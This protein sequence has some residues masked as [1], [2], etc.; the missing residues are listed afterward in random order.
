MA[1]SALPRQVMVAPQEPL[2]T[3]GAAE[4]YEHKVHDLFAGGCHHLVV[5]LRG[6]A[7]IDS[8]GV[9]ALVRGHTTAQRMGGTFTL[10][11]PTAAVLDVLRLSRLDSVFHIRESL[12]EARIS[13]VPWPGLRLTVLGAAL[14]GT[15]W[16]AGVRWSTPGAGGSSN[17]L[18]ALGAGRASAAAWVLIE[19]TKL[20]AAG[21]I[22][23]LVTAVQRRSREKPLTQAMEHAQALLC[24][25]GAMIM[26]IIGESLARAFGIAG[27][28]SI[29]RFRAPVE[30]PKDITVLFLLMAL[31]MAMGLGAFAIAGAGTAFLCVFLV[32]LEHVSGS[33]RRTMMIEVVAEGSDFP[34]A[35][36]QSVFARNGIVFEPREAAHGK[37]VA[38]VYHATLDPGISLEDVS[39]QLME[40]KA[41]VASVSWEP[42]K[43]HG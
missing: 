34:V 36:V 3:G 1:T 41:G 22:G 43:K 7:G 42:P 11:A 18:L 24:V 16:W 9:R 37:E 6:V 12:E 20:V 39:A 19:L 33:Q 31:G 15:L 10:V 32:A 28:A 8:A 23:L 35:H 5:D 14:C 40:G 4:A 27:A 26:M 13:R 30:D 2:V 25:S 29:I 38:M 21:L 17:P